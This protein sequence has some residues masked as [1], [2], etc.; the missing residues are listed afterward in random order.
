MAAKLSK[1]WPVLTRYKR[2]SLARIALPL[3][4]IGTGTVSLGGR[5]NLQDWEIMNRPAKGYTGGE[6]VF[7]LRA[8]PEGGEVIMRVLEGVLQPPY[9]GAFGATAPY[10][11]LP[12]FRKCSFHAA[13]PFGQVW[14]S[15]PDVPV[16][17][18]LEAFNPL[19]PGDAEASGIPVAVLRYV[20]Y[21]RLEVPMAVSVC[22]SIT[23][24]IGFDGKDG[25]AQGNVNTFR[26]ADRIRG[27]ILTSEGVERSAPQYGTMALV[28]THDAVSVKR[29]WNPE[30]RKGLLHFW[31][32]LSDDRWP[33]RWCCRPRG[34]GR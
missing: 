5:G 10:H 32:D 9:E 20:L 3:G 6:A 15:D 34:R 21:N 25:Q 2:R 23:N 26:E 8:Q 16:R 22:G 17:V 31:D 14:L 29:N 30:R 28:T 11:G 7:V 1:R 4:G 19:I 27:L 13:Y 33:R 24:V 12:R 18:R